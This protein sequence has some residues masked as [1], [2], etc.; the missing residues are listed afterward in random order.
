MRHCGTCGLIQRHSTFEGIVAN[1]MKIVV[2]VNSNTGDSA[3][4]ISSCLKGGTKFGDYFEAVSSGEPKKLGACPFG[5][6]CVGINNVS[7]C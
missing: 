7:D 4:I 6:T 1:K 2:G 3:S 5:T